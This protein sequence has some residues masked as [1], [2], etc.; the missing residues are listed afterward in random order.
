MVPASLSGLLL[1]SGLV[2]FSGSRGLPPAVASSVVCLRFR[3]VGLSLVGC[4]AGVDWCFRA[5]LS[6]AAGSVQ[7]FAAASFGVGRGSFAA[8]S[9]AFVRALATGDGVLVSFPSSPCPAGLR[10][11]ASASRCFSG[12]GSGSWASLAFAIGSGVPCW[13]YSP[14]GVPSSWGF[15][16]AGGGWFSFVP[17]AVQSSL[18]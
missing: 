7:V 1:G 16:A 11:W 17:A 4:A 8:R 5:G 9:V 14:C 15:V 3:S 2:G 6:G 12:L 10:P 13:V 18:F